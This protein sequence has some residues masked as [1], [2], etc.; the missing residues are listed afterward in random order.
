L[1]HN[2][3]INSQDYVISTKHGESALHLAAYQNNQEIYQLLLDSNA[4][5]ELKNKVNAT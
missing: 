4:D 5:R 2:Y 3:E 1:L